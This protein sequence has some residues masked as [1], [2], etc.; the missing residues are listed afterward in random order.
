MEQTSYKNKRHRFCDAFSISQRASAFVPQMGVEP[1]LAL[2][3][4]GF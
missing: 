3:R 1:T 2:L 4:T